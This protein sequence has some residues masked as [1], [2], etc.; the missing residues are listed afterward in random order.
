MNWLSQVPCG[1]VRVTRTSGNESDFLTVTPYSLTDC[2]SVA[3]ACETRFWTRTFDMS[4]LDPTSN[5]TSVFSVPSFAFVDL[6]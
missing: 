6:M 1:E 5:E 4:R 2:G 3:F